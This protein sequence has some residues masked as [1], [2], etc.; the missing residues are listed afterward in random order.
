[1]NYDNSLAVTITVTCCLWEL[2]TGDYY[3]H[4][5]PSPGRHTRQGIKK[6]YACVFQSVKKARYPCFLNKIR[7]ISGNVYQLA[8]MR[9]HVH[10]GAL[11]R[12]ASDLFLW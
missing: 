3:L 7:K 5:A 12:S 9:K 8:L 10:R 11:L 6:F 1:V 2:F 4:V